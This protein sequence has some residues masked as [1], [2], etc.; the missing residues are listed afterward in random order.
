MMVLKESKSKRRKKSKKLLRNF[1]QNHKF[2]PNG[3]A[4]G[5][6]RGAQKLSGF[7]L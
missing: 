3:G 5:K 7:V 2:Q 1:T 6:V 4:R